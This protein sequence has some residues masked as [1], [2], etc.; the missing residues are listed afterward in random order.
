MKLFMSKLHVGLQ[1][2]FHKELKFAFQILVGKQSHRSVKMWAWSLCGEPGNCWCQDEGS[3]KSHPLRFREGTMGEER[4]TCF[5][6]TPMKQYGLPTGWACVHTVISQSPRGARSQLH[7]EGQKLPDHDNEEREWRTVV[8]LPNSEP[9]RSDRPD[10]GEWHLPINRKA[11]LSRANV[12]V[13]FP[14][15]YISRQKLASR[16]STEKAVW[17]TGENM[18]LVLGQ[19]SA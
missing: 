10:C 16:K 2:G 7:W 14:S 13:K 8:C 5:L 15:T 1:L 3:P 17:S 6:M 9:S 12:C 11:P 4:N 18:D 19:L